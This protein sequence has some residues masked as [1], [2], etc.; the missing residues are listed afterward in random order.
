MKFVQ[1]LFDVLLLT[2]AGLVLAAS[3]TG[4]LFVLWQI[5]GG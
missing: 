4:G 5:L 3:F 1:R 2:L